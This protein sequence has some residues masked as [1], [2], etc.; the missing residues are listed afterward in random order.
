MVLKKEKLAKC[1]FT[2]VEVLIVLVIIGIIAAFIISLL[3][4]KTSSVKLVSQ[5]QKASNTFANMINQA[6]TGVKMESWNYNTTTEDF[7]QNYI[8]PYIGVA[9]DCGTTKEGCFAQEYQAKNTG[10]AIDN[11]YYKILLSDGSAIAIKIIP[12]CS[13]KNPSECV[14]FIVDVNSTNKPNTWG[15]DVFEFQILNNLSAVVPYGAFEKF[16]NG[17][18]IMA[19]KDTTSEKCLNS[20]ERCCALKIINDGWEMNY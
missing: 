18:W 20:D 1:A 16:E 4:V 12:G 17:K 6:Q 19:E 9:K 3:K 10:P 5:L 11:S 2:L 8:L 15:K 13:D 14:D 7:V